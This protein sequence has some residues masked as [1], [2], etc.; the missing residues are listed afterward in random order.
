M[1][2]LDEAP[3]SLDAHVVVASR[4]RGVGDIVSAARPGSVVPCPVGRLVAVRCAEVVRKHDLSPVRKR[5]DPY[6][7]DGNHQIVIIIVRLA[8]RKIFPMRVVFFVA[9]AAGAP[10]SASLCEASSHNLNYYNVSHTRYQ[11][12][13]IM[14]AR[15]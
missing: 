10:Q 14:A 2:F 12:R 4:I 3:K 1:D 7:A 5:F 11:A 8:S 9:I 13:R 6:A 15:R